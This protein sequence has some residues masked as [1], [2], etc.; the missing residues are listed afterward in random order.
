METVVFQSK[1]AN[2]RWRDM[3]DAAFVGKK[4]IVERHKRPQAVLIN[5]DYWQQVEARLRELEQQ[6][7]VARIRARFL[8]DD[9]DKV[10]GDELLRLLA[11]KHGQDY[12]DRIRAYV[13]THVQ[14]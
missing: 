11:E 13:A 12:V 3:M 4:V 6:A 5:Y 8:A 10:S 2:R 14:D 7:E 9:M 1:D